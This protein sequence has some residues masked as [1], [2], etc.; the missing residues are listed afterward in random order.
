LM[1]KVMNGK[2][3]R[4]KKIRNVQSVHLHPIIPKSIMIK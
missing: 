1:A 3:S 2:Q 4:L